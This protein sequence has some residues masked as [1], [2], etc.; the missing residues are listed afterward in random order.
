MTQII[1]FVPS[2]KVKMPDRSVNQNTASGRI[3]PTMFN[4]LLRK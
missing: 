4:A 1:T 3:E 2:L